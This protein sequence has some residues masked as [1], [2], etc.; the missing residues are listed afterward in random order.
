MGFPAYG[1][2]QSGLPGPVRGGALSI[3]EMYKAL[4]E[5]RVKNE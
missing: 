1:L 2:Q 3:L 4:K 5:G